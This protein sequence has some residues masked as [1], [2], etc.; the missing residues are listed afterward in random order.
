[1]TGIDLIGY[2]AYILCLVGWFFIVRQPLFGISLNFIGGILTIIYGYM[3][4][5]M[6]VIIFNVAWALVAMRAF[7]QAWDKRNA[8]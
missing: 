1:M 4:T 2:I 6:P 8:T 5:A 7:K 3:I